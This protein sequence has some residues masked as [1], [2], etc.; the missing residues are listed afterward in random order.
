MAADLRVHDAHR[1]RARLVGHQPHRPVEVE[2]G[3]RGGKSEAD[4]GGRSAVGDFHAEG[5]LG[6]IG[7]E[8]V[9]LLRDELV[10]EAPG[11]TR[12]PA[13]EDAERSLAAA[14]D[15]QAG[16]V[17]LMLYVPDVNR[18]DPRRP[19]TSGKFETWS[20]AA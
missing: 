17:E 19:L 11:L 20:I 1:G 15:E 7:R 6:V 13:K 3:K 14:N 16:V 10:K 4:V 2:G 5:E 8:P 18:M 12:E 9:T